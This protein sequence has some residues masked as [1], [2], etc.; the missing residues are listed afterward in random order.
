MK[1]H[2]LMLLMPFILFFL[3]QVMDLLIFTFSLSY[4]RHIENKSLIRN[5]INKFQ[6]HIILFT[7]YVAL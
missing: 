2:L 1:L 5:T 3:I 4:S 6:L 7:K